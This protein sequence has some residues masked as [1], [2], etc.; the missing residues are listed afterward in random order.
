MPNSRIY[1][2]LW[3][4]VG[5]LALI[6]TPIYPGSLACR[7]LNL[8]LVSV[9]FAVFSFATFWAE[10]VTTFV[11][12]PYLVCQHI[13]DVS[14]TSNRIQDEVFHIP[15]AQAYCAGRY[16]VWDPKLTTPPGL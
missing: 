6:D 5:G 13:L 1:Q 10:Q 16:D 14:F 12:E 9:F 2:A 8:A 4:A 3:W 11:P 7:S 15:Q